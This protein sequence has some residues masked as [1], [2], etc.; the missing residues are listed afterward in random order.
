MSKLWAY[1]FPLIAAL[2]IISPARAAN[3]NEYYYRRI[4]GVLLSEGGT[5]TEDFDLMA[6]T[7]RNRIARG[8]TLANVLDQYS[9][10]YTTPTEKHIAHLTHILYAENS[11]LSD[12][13]QVAYFFYSDAYAE[14]WINPNVEPIVVLAGH[15][16]YRYED[17]KNLWRK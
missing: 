12:A 4:A 17:Y 9:A 2:L 11:E 13:C 15:H 6:C 8:S 14:R 16:Y 5:L 10:A 3:N 7:I 1:I